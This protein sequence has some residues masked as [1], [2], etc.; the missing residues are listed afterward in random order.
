M[1]T[2]ETGKIYAL[3][4]GNFIHSIWGVD[5]RVTYDEN[6]YQVIEIT[7]IVPQPQVN[8]SYKDGVFTPA[9]IYTPPV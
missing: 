3:I 8:D 1:K 9:I 6:R 7:D 4:Q 2:T 5:D